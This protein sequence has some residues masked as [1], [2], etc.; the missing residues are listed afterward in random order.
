MM[1]KPSSINPRVVT[2]LLLFSSYTLAQDPS[3]NPPQLQDFDWSTV[4]SG[5]FRLHT[6]FVMTP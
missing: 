1:K 5:C 3:L 2:G 6:R 4:R